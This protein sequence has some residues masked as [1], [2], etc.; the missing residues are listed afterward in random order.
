[1]FKAIHI[2]DWALGI[3]RRRSVRSAEPSGV[4][5]ISSGGLGDTVLFALL[6]PRFLQ[7]AQAGER[8][9]VLLRHNAAKMD[10]VLPP[11]VSV[12]A[13]NFNNFH[14]SLGYRAAISETLY[15]ENFRLAVSTDHLRHPDLDE[16]LI[17]AAAAAES[18]AMEPRSWRKYDAALQLNRN[19][20][21]RLFDSGPVHLDK[22]VRWARFADW[23]TGRAETLPT[24]RLP[25][26]ILPAPAAVDHRTVI[27]QPFSAVKAKQ[28][29]LALYE[30]VIKSLPEDVLVVITGATG[31]LDGNPEYRKLLE[32]PRV[33][34]DSSTFAGITPVLRAATLVIS[35]D[36]A[37]M[38]LAVATGTP[39]L[40]LASAAYVG[41]IVPYDPAITPENAQ[42]LYQPMDCEGCLGACIHPL[43]E[44]MY[45]CV[46][47]LDGAKVLE[48]VAGY[49]ESP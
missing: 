20:Y 36:T 3:K 1:M 25:D 29:P 32:D 43:E 48:A 12:M 49:L 17:A 28:S 5:L 2:L 30:A 41:E 46:A 31:D 37:L 13:V 27:I 33:S 23:I 35:V 39:T 38:H 22:V 9:T 15:Q 21:S 11:E 44:G 26:S 14:K 4:L 8:V 45:R 7:M 42:F 6:L 19:L 18:V 34:F 24:V 47:A 16:A 10:F 40:C